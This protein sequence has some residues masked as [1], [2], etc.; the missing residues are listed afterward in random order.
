MPGLPRRL[1][2]L[3]VLVTAWA[4]AW[5]LVALAIAHEVDG[6]SDLS[7]TVTRVGKAV[8]ASGE[9]LDG[10]SGLP[11]LS[12]TLDEPS[13]RIREAG[14]SAVASGRSSGESVDQ[15]SVL[16]AISIALIPTFPLVCL[17]LPLRATA[18][19]ERRTARALAAE[20]R[21]DPRFEQFL[22]R[23]ALETLP[24]R[25]LEAISPRPWR[26]YMEGRF[27]PLARAELERLGVDA[28]ELRG[29]LPLR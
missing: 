12:D 26:E 17:Y 20:A 2:V 1:L 10:L 8:V 4:L 11:L 13:E 16:L 23:R 27:G 19:R 7:V 15:L 14:R 5:I 6:L 24:Y 28:R 25:R 18:V 29:D 9:A 3:D 21:D 22:A